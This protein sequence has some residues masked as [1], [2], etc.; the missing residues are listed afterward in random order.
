MRPALF[1]GRKVAIEQAAGVSS[2]A[3]HWGAIDLLGLVSMVD[4]PV[5]GAVLAWARKE[6]GLSEEE[7]A[8]RLKSTPK[9]KPGAGNG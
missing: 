2:G 6:R 1:F 7:A 4:V 9:R 5:N 8:N 3:V